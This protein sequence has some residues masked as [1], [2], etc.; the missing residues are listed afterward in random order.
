[1]TRRSVALRAVLVVALLVGARP[2]VHAQVATIMEGSYANE[3]LA[4]STAAVGFTLLTHSPA[5]APY[6][7]ALASFVVEGCA[8]RVWTTGS[9][10]TATVGKKLNIGD[11]AVVY[12]KPAVTKF[13]AIRD[14]ACAVDATL[15]T[16]FSR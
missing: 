3:S 6:P 4:V 14:T 16:E 2:P 5:N 7:V 10:P 11:S 13:R 12:G 9:T 1:M 8:V 15:Q